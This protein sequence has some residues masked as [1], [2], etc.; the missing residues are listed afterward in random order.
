MFIN[1][2]KGLGMAMNL[3]TQWILLVE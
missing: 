3:D 2:V 1:K